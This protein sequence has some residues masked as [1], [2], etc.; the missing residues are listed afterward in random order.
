[1]SSS[2]WG[3]ARRG[4]SAINFT[5]GDDGEL[6]GEAGRRS[7]DLGWR[8][9]TESP[10]AASRFGELSAATVLAI[11]HGTDPA[12]TVRLCRQAWALG[13]TMVE[14]PIRAEG[15]LASLAAAIAAGRAENHV[16]GA[17]TVTSPELVRQVADLGAAF[18]V[19]PGWTSG[20]PRRA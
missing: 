10:A 19:A 17:G 7:D 2:R 14:V 11:L 20:S 9:M 4:K 1:M 8:E 15:D 13:V 3:R 12:G 5:G 16:V 18:T 6:G